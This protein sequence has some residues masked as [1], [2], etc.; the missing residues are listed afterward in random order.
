MVGSRARKG[1]RVVVAAGG[2]LREDE[3]KADRER[4]GI[5]R[6]GRK[7]AR[8]RYIRVDGG[9]PDDDDDDDDG[10]G[11]RSFADV[12]EDEASKAYEE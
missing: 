7:A 9:M 5:P 11:R 6:G 12:V 1:A 3:K 10:G 8:E 2:A 4:R